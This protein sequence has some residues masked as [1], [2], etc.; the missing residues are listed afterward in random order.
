MNLL[1]AP[2]F[3]VG[4]LVIVVSVLI[5]VMSMRVNESP[6]FMRGTKRVWFEVENASGLI[7]K[8]PVNVAGIRVGVIEDIKLQDGRAIVE[9]VI[10]SDVILTEFSKIE[11]RANGILGDK[12]V[13]IIPG[14]LQSPPLKSPEQQ[15][16]VVEDNASIDQL[17]GEISKITKSLS[18]VADNIRDATEGDR[19]KPLGK[20]ITNLET[21]TGNLSDLVHEK[22]KE[23]SEMIGYMRDITET[24]DGIVNDESEAGFSV[25]FKNSMASLERTLASVDEISHKIKNGE[26]TIGRLVN[27]EETVEELNTAIAGVNQFIQAGSKLQTAFDYYSHYFTNGNGVRSYIGTR[28]QPGPDRFYEIA[29]ISSPEGVITRFT[30][31][32]STDG[33]PSTSTV[34]KNSQQYKLR[35]TALFGKTF[36]NLSVKGGLIENR[37]G[38]GLEY[39]FY[40]NHFRLSLDAFDFDTPNLRAY[41][42]YNFFKGLYVV[43]GQQ[44]I[45]EDGKNNSAGFIGAGLFLTND[46]IKYALSR[47]NL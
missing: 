44:Y 35:F 41:L 47:I 10:R 4:L 33:G 45:L 17:V 43:G 14:P 7:K 26:G 6:S 23:V 2:E 18:I 8:S 28:I 38:L 39:N 19:E 11:I 30:R 40:R 1:N 24:L 16:Q 5:G 25:R 42:R 34:Q 36:Y 3:K 22:K 46:D 27:D 32:S 13:E 20:I 31:T 12:H 37:G 21:L 9:M 29:G 15:I